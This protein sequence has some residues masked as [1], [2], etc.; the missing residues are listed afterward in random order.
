MSAPART[1]RDRMLGRSGP[2]VGCD[3]CFAHLDRYAELVLRGAGADLVLPGMHAHLAGCPAC[4][5]E[6][7]SLLALLRADAH[8]EETA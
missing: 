3:A 8:E 6:Y 2:D 4:E 5:E 1:A 7:D